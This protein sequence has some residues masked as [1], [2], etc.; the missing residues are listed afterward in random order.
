M[1]AAW[2][3]GYV[4]MSALVAAPPLAAT[5]SFTVGL[6]ATSATLTR[7]RNGTISWPTASTCEW[8][9][10]VARAGSMPAARS[11]ATW[12]KTSWGSRLR[13]GAVG[14]DLV[15]GDEHEQLDAQLLQA[16]PVLER[17][18][19]VPDVERAGRAVAGQD[20]EGAGRAGDSLLEQGAAVLGLIERGGYGMDRRHRRPPVRGAG[21]APRGVT[22]VA[23]DEAG[24]PEGGP[25]HCAW[26]VGPPYCGHRH[27]ACDE[28]IMRRRV[29]ARRPPRQW[30]WPHLAQMPSSRRYERRYSRLASCTRCTY[31]R[32]SENGIAAIV[33]ASL[34][35][36]A[37]T[38]QRSSLPSPPLY[39][40]SAN[41]SLPA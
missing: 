24:P 32:V 2:W 33:S 1:S 8:A 21:G 22:L 13:R 38:I 15:V 12:P 39:A 31:V 7:L 16:H 27:D 18:E 29:G 5:S 20:A 3:T 11:P 35:R 28:R 41:V 30:G 36:S 14:E 4:S 23:S 17:A 40:A 25:S 34:R 6:R 37:A 26:H 19:Q 9:Q 10:I